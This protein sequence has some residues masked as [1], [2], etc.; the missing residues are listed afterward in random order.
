MV[1]ILF[2]S[3][4]IS[5]DLIPLKTSLPIKETEGGI[6]WESEIKKIIFFLEKIKDGDPSDEDF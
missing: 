6:I 3:P 2:K 4:I 5:G 1:W